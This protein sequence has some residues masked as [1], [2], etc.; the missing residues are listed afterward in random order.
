M[1]QP[2]M[3]LMIRDILRIIRKIK[4]LISKWKSQGLRSNLESK[5][6]RVRQ[7]EPKSK[8]MVMKREAMMIMMTSTMMKMVNLNFTHLKAVVR[9]QTTWL[10]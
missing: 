6:L 10:Q 1:T 7:A 8:N 5:I 2:M 9:Y 4:A 3:V